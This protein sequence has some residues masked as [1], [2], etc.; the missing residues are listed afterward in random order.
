MRTRE[1]LCALALVCVCVCLT[2]AMTRARPRLWQVFPSKNRAA[3]IDEI[4]MEFRS[5]KGVFVS[6]AAPATLSDGP[7]SPEEME[8]VLCSLHVR[9]RSYL[10]LSRILYVYVCVRPEQM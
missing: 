3:L 9:R 2:T 7:L 5:C 4:R 1:E 8:L 10:S 6:R